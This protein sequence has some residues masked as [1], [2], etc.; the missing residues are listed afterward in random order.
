ML[1]V[2]SQAPEFE[3]KLDDGSSFKLSELRGRKNIVLYFYPRDFSGGCTR[4]ACSFR[5]NY[6]S[7]EAYDAVII[8]VSAD[9]EESHR[10]F[11]EEHNLSFPIIADAGRK[12]SE[13]YDLRPILG[14]LRPRVTYVIDKQGV[15]RAAFQ[16]NVFI[17]RHLGDTLDALA[18]IQAGVA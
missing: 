1:A 4:Q 12:V 18:N 10:R 16:H 11:K 9:T 15:I 3:A 8:G 2:G 17:A 6:S 14:L 5:D 7:V 13:L